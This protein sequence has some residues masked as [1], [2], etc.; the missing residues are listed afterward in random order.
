MTVIERFSHL[1][2]QGQNIDIRTA[3]VTIMQRMVGMEAAVKSKVT[4]MEGMSLVHGDGRPI[5]TFA[6][7]G[8]PNQQSLI[9]EY[10]IFRGDLARILYDLTK[11]NPRIKYVFGEQI[12]SVQQQ[13]EKA[14]DDDDDGPVTVEFANGTP[15]SEYDLIVA[16]DGATSRTRAMALN[17]GVRDYIHS[18]N[19]WVAYF[20]LDRD[21]LEGS[22]HGI[23]HSSVGG[24]FLALGPDP[25]GVT[26]VTVMAVNPRPSFSSSS[27][28]FSSGG[29]GDDATLPF[30]NA[31]K[32]GDEALKAYVAE[33]LRGSGWKSDAVIECLLNQNQN[34]NPQS[35]ST[36]TTTVSDFYASEIVQ[37]KIPRLYHNRF[38]L[39]GDAGYAPGP[40]GAGTSLAIAGAYVL[41]G[42]VGSTHKGDLAAGLQA[43]EE[44]MRPIIVDMQKI[45]PG[46]PTVM[47]PQTAWGLRLR[48]AILGVIW[49]GMALAKYFA[50]LPGLWAS[51]F[52]G[53]KYGIPEYEF[54]GD[55]V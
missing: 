53:D 2:T 3:G 6:P 55:K 16:C 19:T 31:A 35:P 45:P 34:Q 8:D 5:I 22:K 12:A 36:P 37:V 54:E 18:V 48:N 13:Q 7:T 23:A 47:A 29:K 27:S 40:T 20:S 39:V 15:T 26:R 41:A 24:R 38:V 42:E 51:S 4:P 10:E 14:D 49:W 17:C 32:Q 30:R 52:G 33:Y 1:R 11:D 44:R 43:Y 25:T 9:S 50:W 21:L 28:S 46:I